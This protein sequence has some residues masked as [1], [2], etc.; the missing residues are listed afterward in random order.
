[1]LE[2]S[3]RPRKSAKSESYDSDARNARAAALAELRECAGMLMQAGYALIRVGISGP[4]KNGKRRKWPINGW[5]LI[6]SPSEIQSGEYIAA[7]HSQSMR[8]AYDVDEG[9]VSLLIKEADRL[10]IAYVPVQTPS[11]G[12]HL[13]CEYINAAKPAA[14]PYEWR[15]LKGEIRRGRSWTVIYDPRKLIEWHSRNA[16]RHSGAAVEELNRILLASRP[17]VSRPLDDAGNMPTGALKSL[18]AQR[19]KPSFI[20]KSQSSSKVAELA[21][22][23]VSNP[24]LHYCTVAYR[25]KLFNH[26]PRWR[27]ELEYG[28]PMRT[29]AQSGHNAAARDMSLALDRADILIRDFAIEPSRAWKGNDVRR[30]T[31]KARS[32]LRAMLCL[33]GRY[34]NRECIASYSTIADMSGASWSTVERMLRKF[35]DWKIFDKLEYERHEGPP[36]SPRDARA[37]QFYYHITCKFVLSADA[38]RSLGLSFA[39]LEAAVKQLELANAAGLEGATIFFT[40]GCDTNSLKSKAVSGSDAADVENRARSP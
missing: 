12:W 19:A 1:M 5:N 8:I 11:G 35:V 38:K 31:E 32:V 29:A 25:E 15:G 37:A 23:A 22:S 9:E 16:G 39:L 10:G 7:V 27:D 26:Y 4:D 40:D 36:P 2:T 30:I 21:R 24:G 33:M 6:Q 20:A 14:Q 3:Q 17:R 13:W 18:R 34:G 28:D